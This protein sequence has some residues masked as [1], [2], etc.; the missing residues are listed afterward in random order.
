MQSLPWHSTLPEQLFVPE[1][2][3]LPIV[4]PIQTSPPQL[5]SP[6]HSSE[7]E[8]FEPP[9]VTPPA[10]DRS[11]PHEMSQPSDFVQSM[12]L[13]QLCLPSQWMWHG[14][15]AGHVIFD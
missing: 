2:V 6:L 14:N 12:A 15:P 1:Q 10:Q 7:Q 11:L 9:H 5:S 8:A 13:P 4:P 3:S